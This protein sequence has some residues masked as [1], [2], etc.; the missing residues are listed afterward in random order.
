MTGDY[1]T[2]CAGKL[3][4]RPASCRTDPRSFGPF[5]R[6]AARKASLASMQTVPVNDFATLPEHLFVSLPGDQP[7]DPRGLS[8]SGTQ[9]GL[10]SR[11]DAPSVHLPIRRTGLCWGATRAPRWAA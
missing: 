7:P 4:P 5:F 1:D 6:A 2:P 3:K 11:K 8:H 10:I 9:M